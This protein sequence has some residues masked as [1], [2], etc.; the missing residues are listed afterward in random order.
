MS[1]FEKAIAAAQRN[2]GKLTRMPNGIWKGQDTDLQRFPSEVVSELVKSRKAE[3]T[4]FKEG[5]KAGMEITLT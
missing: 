5:T 2:G 1:T 4:A 3:Y